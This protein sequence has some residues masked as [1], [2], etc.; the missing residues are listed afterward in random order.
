MREEDGEIVPVVGP[1]LSP[2]RTTESWRSLRARLWSALAAS[3]LPILLIVASDTI[4]TEHGRRALE[5]FRGAVPAADVVEA[6]SGHD[7]LA[8]A[9]RETIAA[10]SSFLLRQRS[11]A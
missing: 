9:P 2:L 8:D 3:T 6:D 7:V 11:V 10:I 1:R 4:G 5:R